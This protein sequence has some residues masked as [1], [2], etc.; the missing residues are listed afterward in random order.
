MEERVKSSPLLNRFPCTRIPFGIDFDVFRPLD[1]HQCRQAIGIPPVANVLSFRHDYK[2]GFKGIEYIEEALAA[3]EPKRDTYL[4]SIGGYS[5]LEKLR[6]KY[7]I[8]QM[9]L[10]EN[11]VLISTILNASDIFLSPSIAEA[12]GLMPIEAMACGTPVVVFEGTALPEV[13]HAPEGGI[14]VPYRDSTALKMAVEQLLEDKALY[15]GYV[16]RGLEIVRK[17]YP[18]RYYVQRHLDLYENSLK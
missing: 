17:E 13:I 15:E 5:K 4:I 2:N 11:S 6:K 1:K 9:G 16:R 7:K 18:L 10:L 14:A 3:L 8:I 12:F